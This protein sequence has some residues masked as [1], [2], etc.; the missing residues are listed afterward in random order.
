MSAF[1][2][3]LAFPVWMEQPRTNLSGSGDLSRAADLFALL[4]IG[5]LFFVLGVI[6]TCTWMIW[7]RNVAPKPHEQ[8]LM[9]L[10]HE[11]PPQPTPASDTPA[12]PKALW[13]KPDD[14]W[15]QDR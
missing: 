9:E 15:K 11:E 12:L 14:W 13:E 8:L 6:A 1:S 4:S 5:F 10:H 7:R 3:P 2:F